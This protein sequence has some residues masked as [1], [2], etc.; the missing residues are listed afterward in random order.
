MLKKVSLLVCTNRPNQPYSRIWKDVI[1][2]TLLQ[3]V[4]LATQN[5]ANNYKNKEQKV[6]HL[7]LENRGRSKALNSGLLEISSFA[8]GLTD[9]DCLINKNWAMEALSTLNDSKIGL[10]YG[11]TKPYKPE[12]N[13]NKFCPSTFDKKPNVFSITDS[14]GKHWLDVGFDNNAVIKNEVFKNIGP[15]KWWIGP[16]CLIPAAEDGEFV[17]RALIAGYKIAYNPK[18]LVYHDR[19]LTKKEFS[20]QLEIYTYGG[21]VVYGFYAMQGVTELKSIFIDHFNHFFYEAKN[22]LRKLVKNKFSSKVFKSFLINTKFLIKGILIAF[23]FAKIIPIPP[24]E[25]VVKR[26]YKSKSLV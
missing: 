23:L 11:H 6:L 14:L 15:Y 18:M 1:D 2:Q 25:N 24:N 5:L 9:D 26:F 7:P 21:L 22:D 4:I 17:I 19:F 8:V 13:K 20:D 16:G 12:L 3:K 10:V